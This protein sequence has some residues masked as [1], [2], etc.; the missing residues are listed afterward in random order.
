MLQIQN[1]NDHSSKANDAHDKGHDKGT[2]LLSRP[3]EFDVTATPSLCHSGHPRWD[4]SQDLDDGQ[5]SIRP[6]TIFNHP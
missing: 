5:L 3:R 4:I 2:G 6:N 1:Q